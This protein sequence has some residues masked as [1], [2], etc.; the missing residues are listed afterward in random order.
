[1]RRARRVAN[2]Y[3][4]LLYRPAPGGSSRV[5]LAVSKRVGNAVRRNRL[6][7]LLRESFRLY[8]AR[9]GDV[10]MDVVVQVQAAAASLA[11]E[12]LAAVSA[13]FRPLLE[14]AADRVRRQ[15]SVSVKGRASSP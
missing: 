5:G 1:M 12:G 13:S 15:R 2:P 4:R 3:F 6:K 10:P 14:T 8:E 9:D 7:R 11:E